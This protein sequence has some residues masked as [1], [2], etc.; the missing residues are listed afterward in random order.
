MRN[1]IRTFTAVACP[2]R[3]EVPY[4]KVYPTVPPNVEYGLTDLDQS[5]LLPL[6]KS[7]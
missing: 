7:A 2:I 4:R 3:D 6:D 5:L 1:E